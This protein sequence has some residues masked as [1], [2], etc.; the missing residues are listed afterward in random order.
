MSPPANSFFYDE[1][2]MRLRTIDWS[3]PPGDF[4]VQLAPTLAR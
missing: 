2:P 1:L 3:K 4:E